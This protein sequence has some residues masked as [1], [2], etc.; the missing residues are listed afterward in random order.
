MTVYEQG[1]VLTHLLV[2]LPAFLLGTWLM[3][4]RKGT[5]NHRAMGKVYLLLM[6]FTGVIT[7]FIPAQVGPQWLGH[8]GYLHLLSLLT[9]YTVPT[10]WLAARRHQWRRHAAAMIGLYVGG[11][12][13]A[14]GFALMPGRLLH[15][16]LFGG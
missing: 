5:P 16:W 3:I 4:R 11:L 10:A 13:V 2:I 15:V 9:L 12:L 8:F 14:G 1:L 6:L 7:L